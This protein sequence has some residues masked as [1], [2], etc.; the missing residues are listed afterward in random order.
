MNDNEILKRALINACKHLRELVGI[1][2]YNTITMINL[3]DADIN[4]D[5]WLCYFID[6]AEK[7]LTAERIGE[8]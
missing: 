1:N 3:A 7:E 2:P 8:I 5:T 4:G 6:E